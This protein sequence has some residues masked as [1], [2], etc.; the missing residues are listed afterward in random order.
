MEVTIGISN[1]HVHLT[2]KDYEILFEDE[3]TIYKYINQP[4][5]FA[6]NSFV[7]I[8][9]KD[10]VIKHV[11]VLGPYRDY[12]Q[13]EISLTDAKYLNL[14]PP[15][16][17]SGD[18]KGSSPITLIGPKGEIDLKEGCIIA[19]RHI[20]ILPEQMK[21]YGLEGLTKVSVLLKGEKGGII[22]NVYLRVGKNSYFE[23]H[24]DRDDANSHMVNSGDIG[25]I[26]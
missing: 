23:L 14:N 22:N 21:L 15:I 4:K 17:Q 11:R 2:K 12:N 5:Q 1:R 20:H 24:L 26:L 25:I 19:D 3:M 8:K 6:S 18:I 7:D 10:R 16:R 9:N 13:V